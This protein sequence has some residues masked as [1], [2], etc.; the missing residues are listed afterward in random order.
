M[1]FPVLPAT[2]DAL[3]TGASALCALLLARTWRRT[4][5]RLLLWTAVSFILLAL[6]SLLLVLDLFVFRK[7]DLWP[8]RTL[9][10]GAALLVLLCGFIWEAD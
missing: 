5:S 2:T 4:R 7:T 10:L 8:L 6:N 9:S 1:S 3:C